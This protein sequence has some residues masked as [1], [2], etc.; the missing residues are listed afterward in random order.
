MWIAPRFPTMARC[1][2][3]TWRTHE[4][5]GYAYPLAAGRAAGPGRG[6]GVHS[7]HPGTCADGREET[8]GVESSVLLPATTKG[9]PPSWT[10]KAFRQGVVAG[11]N[12]CGAEAGAKVLQRGGSAI[13]A[14]V[15]IAYAQNVVEPQ[16]AGTGGGGFTMIHLMRCAWP[17]PTAACGRAT[18]TSSMSRPRG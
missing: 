2:T 14:A 3:P 12:P 8:L 5:H 16:S 6:T 11:V 17:L 10:G 13:D 18:P 4:H 9:E 15:A 1:P 7:C